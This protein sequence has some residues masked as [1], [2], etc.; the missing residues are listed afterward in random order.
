MKFYTS[1]VIGKKVTNFCGSY[2]YL[3]GRI[4]IFV[5]LG[6]EF[7]ALIAGNSLGVDMNTYDARPD[8]GERN[9]GI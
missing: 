7:Y 6:I 5:N 2:K 1:L 3:S 8:G 4:R 9:Y